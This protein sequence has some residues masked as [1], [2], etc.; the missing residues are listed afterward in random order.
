MKKKRSKEKSREKKRRKEEK[1]K[2]RKE[3]KKKRRKEEGLCKRRGYRNINDWCEKGI[4]NSWD[5][6]YFTY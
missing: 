3:E 5:G 2:R 6:K 1:K 4:L